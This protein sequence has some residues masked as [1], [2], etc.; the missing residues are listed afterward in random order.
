MKDSTMVAIL[1]ARFKAVLVLLALSVAM[2]M[3]PSVS[4][5]AEPV[6]QYVDDFFYKLGGG[7]AIPRGAAGYV[8]YRIGARFTITPGYSCGNFS[9]E[10]NLEQALNRIRTQIQGLPDQLGMAA[11][12]MVSA[13][14][15]Y[16]LKNYAADVYGILMWNLD[17]SIDLF[18][19]QYKT[20]ET[21]E[22]EILR[23]NEG[24]NP[25]AT[26]TRAAVLNQY[27]WG[28][29][30]GTT[31]DQTTREAQTD[32]GRRGFNFLGNGRGTPDKPIPLK[33]DLM[34]LAYNNRLGRVE[35]PLD[36]SAPTANQNDALVQTWR[37]PQL[38][39]DWLVAATGEFWLVVGG[40]APK[41]SAPGIGVR[42]EIDLLTDNY[43][44]ALTNA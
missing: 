19:I 13:L 28:G 18:R 38:A 44:I 4:A 31:I 16:L 14:P 22:A 26:A 32:P 37:T 25:Y 8:T 35:N 3:V 12:G 10:Q 5:Q 1:K 11:T 21:L 6:T 15:M 40:S 30:N 41:Q 24:Y 20:C 34:V 39:A 2:L 27:I 17:Q 42:P 23:N 29:E 36:V 33:H 9:L 7:R 43:E